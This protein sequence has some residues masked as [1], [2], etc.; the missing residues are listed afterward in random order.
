MVVP[1]REARGRFTVSFSESI[2]WIF[3][4]Q[5]TG[6]GTCQRD[7]KLIM[8]GI[9]SDLQTGGTFSTIDAIEKYLDANK[10]ITQVE[11]ELL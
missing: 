7:L 4:G 11:N 3:G 6:E 10:Q 5:A 9:I 8:L 1:V 2:G